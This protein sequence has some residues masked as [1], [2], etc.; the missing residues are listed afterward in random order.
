MATRKPHTKSRNGCLQCKARHVKCDETKP[1]CLNCDDYNVPCEYPTSKK[2][3]QDS[4]REYVSPYP[5]LKPATINSSSD[6]LMENTSSSRGSSTTPHVPQIENLA[7]LKLLH[8]Y[9]TSVARSLAANNSTLIPV[10]QDYMVQLAFEHHFLLHGILAIAALHLSRIHPLQSADYLFQAS[11]HQDAGLSEFR[12]IVLNFSPDLREPVFCFSSMLI[13][14][15]YG[16]PFDDGD[17]PERS[18]DNII[19]CLSL[20]RGVGPLIGPYWP[21]LKQSEL[22]KLVPQD[23]V[24]I[25]WAAVDETEMAKSDDTPPLQRLYEATKTI[26]DPEV[27]E[28]Y[29]S[30]IRNLH[31]A[32]IRFPQYPS[33]SALSILKIWP[34][35][36]SPE[37]MEL[38]G[39]K[40]PEALVILAYFSVLLGRCRWYWF[41]EGWSERVVDTV[42]ALLDDEWKD[43]LQWPKA[44]LKNRHPIAPNNT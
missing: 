21:E 41:M 40:H 25:D 4:P 29:T 30:A 44:E 20:I 15:S 16:L 39:N 18:L 26:K 7:D 1:G 31:G 17:N 12:N 6:V 14:Y 9:T 33:H 34:V 2:N 10:W 22:Y 5:P 32:F 38:L 42:E 11:K 28:A 35:R 8:H 3:R 24:N 27:A 36:L 23:I 37:F 43:W 13:P 19:H